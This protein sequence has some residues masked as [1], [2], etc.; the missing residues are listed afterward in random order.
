VIRKEPLGPEARARLRHEVAMLERLRGVAG[1]PQLLDMPVLPDSIVLADVG[2]TSLDDH[3]Q[4]VDVGDLVEFGVALAMVV[5]AMHRRG[6]MHR[7]IS[8]GN[9]LI[10]DSNA[11][12]LVDFALAT[13]FAE[14]R[15]EFTHH[16]EIRGTLAYL[17][18]EQTGRTGRPVD[19][20]ADLYALGA[21]LYELATGHAPFGAGDPLRLVHDHLARVPVPPV[22]LNPA[23]EA[24][25][26]DI[27]MH[28]LEK[29]PDSRYQTAEGVLYDLQRLQHL[30]DES[31][32]AVPPRV[33]EHD[34]PV[35]L[36]PPSSLVGRDDEV[37]MLASALN[38]ALT[39]RCRAVLVSGAPGVGKT[40]MIDQLR[41]VVTGS[42][43]WF[44]AGKFDPYRR[45]LE[46]DAIYRAL[47]ALGRLLLA[48]PEEELARLRE[49][50][51]QA[52]GANAG[53]LTAMLPEFAALLGVAPDPGAPL[54]AEV[55][56]QR[57]VAAA[58]R[59]VASRKRPLVM[60]IDDLQWAARTRLGFLDVLLNEEPVHGML[61]VCA[62]RDDALV[63]PHPLAGSLARWQDHPGVG[64]LRLTNLPVSG[65]V[66]M[67]AEMLHVDRATAAALA[68]LID[69]RTRGN[70]YETVELLN[71]L[72]CDGVLTAT[73]AGWRW[74]EAG[75]RAHL[76]QWEGAGLLPARVEAMPSTSRQI[77]EAMACLGG[78]TELSLLQT[79]TDTPAA[80]V[81]RALDPAL[82][83]G[84][85]VVEPGIHQAVRFRHDRIRE[86]IL[87]ALGPQRRRT[88]Q[89]AMARR[90]AEVPE[91]VAV[92]AEQYLPVVHAVDDV[93]ERRRVVEL[94][95]RAADQA[96]MIGDHALVS[97]LLTAAL[98]LVDPAEVATL[99]DL[100]S[101][102]H[103]ALYSLGRLEEADDEYRRIDAVRA[104]PLARADATVLQVHS[105]THR[106]LFAQAT[107][108]GLAALRELGIAVP[109]ADALPVE[110]DHQ[111]ERL[112]QWLSA[113]APEDD[114][115][116]PDLTD[117]SLVSAGELINAML[118]PV[119]FAAD[120]AR[121]AWLSLEAL[122][123]WIEHGPG[124]TLV[125]P[126]CHV[127]HATVELRGD[128]AA[129]YR[130][131]RRI[132][133]L[134][135]ARGYQPET[136]NARFLF[137]LL[138]WCFEPIE[139]CVRATR[140]AREGL[141]A[142]G[143]L[144]LAGY[145]Y[146][147]AAAAIDCSPSVESFAAQVEEGLSFVRRT[148]GEQ[149]VQ[150]LDSYRR[151]VRVL[152]GEGTAEE[153]E[154]GPI[155]RYADN[156]LALCYA[157]VTRALAAVIFGD[158][159]DLTRHTAAAMTL[160]TTVS[161]HYVTAVARVLRGLALC[162]Q[163]RAGG[164]DQHDALVAEFDDV[165]QWL[166]ERAADAPDNF[167]HLLRLI[168]AERAWAVGDF[169]AAAL[170]FDAARREVARH[171][172]PWQRALIAERAGRFFLA[173]GLEQTGYDALAEA[174]TDYAAWGATAKVDQLDWAYPI[175]RS[176]HG[177]DG[178]HAVA[179]P[180]DLP[181]ARST[182]ST[183]T[184]DLL[185]ILAASQALSS[186]TSVQRLHARVVEVLSEM[187]GATG[188]HL[189]LWHDD[190]R[191]WLLPAS[192]DDAVPLSGAGAQRVAPLSVLR[193]VERTRE[194]LV[195][196]DAI[197]DDRFARD[198]YFAE[199]TSC[200]LLAVPILSRGTLRAVLVLENRLIRGA[201]STERLD[202]VKL[203]A[204]QLAV[205][206]E[207]AKVYSAFR[208]VADE[209]AALR[210][211]A[212]LVA[213]GVGPELVFA[214]VAEEVGALFGADGTAIVRFE[215]D[216]QATVMGGYG[217]EHS[218]PGFRGTPDPRLA[219]ASVQA[220]G[221]AARRD[222]DDPVTGVVPES[223]SLGVRS[224]VASPIV[225]EGRVWGA[226]GVGSRNGRL[227]PDT[228]HRLDEFTALVATAIANAESRAELATSRARIV[229][230]SD[231][232][233]RRIER[234]LHDGAQ[235]RLVHTVV[236]LKLARE[237]LENADTEAV[238]LVDEALENAE[239]SI[240]EVRELARGIHPRI[241]SLG[242]LG[243]ALD[244]LARRSRL[245]V[246]VELRTERRPPERTEVTAYYVISEALTNAVKH[247][248]ATALGVTVDADAAEAVLHVTVHDD[249]A[250]GAD[251]SLGTGL[252]G[253]KDRVEALG[254]RF[255]L[256]SPRGRGTTMHIDLPLAPAAAA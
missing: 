153:A 72:R 41:P 247:A 224:A 7:D 212:T 168:E 133:A 158:P 112:Y 51:L 122:R 102:R 21:T 55:R 104:T 9:I 37:V 81:E 117:P 75:V 181:G 157:H 254:G 127:A 255:S 225:V 218:Q 58:L 205:S 125:G 97:T 159:L 11:P 231:Q 124:R 49:G 71:A 107:D 64:H 32:G 222:A 108:L 27:I 229:A 177:A 95:Q 167:L 183:G 10:S 24:P 6:V 119:Y 206:L 199:I 164:D 145:T 202:A 209:Q 111:F 230:A 96:A 129:G 194:P 131:T 47:R 198:A 151:L 226:M 246:T 190:A 5:A 245:P 220:T 150:W 94:L 39:G 126:A 56:G 93:A 99:L 162:G 166:S 130:T 79:A 138:G 186:E 48:E 89:L 25:L 185:G 236:T 228:G 45:D 253:I 123:I 17:A 33:G 52:T 210:R 134:S 197:R 140:R 42:D 105:L 200:S 68:E 250:G 120:H 156:P 91:L 100:H 15:P 19:E 90:L 74:D 165:A 23:V 84:L 73:S 238:E 82:D 14:I 219:L 30:P 170:A 54:T 155:E 98:P 213:R 69:P 43:G 8:P 233:R 4:P 31:A 2:G 136:A 192:A 38:R 249:G 251:P 62:Y 29:E 174:R 239:G 116:R 22:K 63:A 109:A 66:A 175:L 237:A 189:L 187:T 208:R 204:G 178:G 132:L 106:N 232:T 243:P 240:E 184:I 176:R 1:I 40:A 137:G 110:V 241:L 141:I 193:Y 227:L 20:R 196:N 26:S 216:G 256:D 28:L 142:G 16:T 59:V 80:E 242:G 161:G 76:G 53:L 121:V 188:V 217:F 180:P 44:V 92:A 146:H 61:V 128:Y 101:G 172:R 171:D 50:I 85:L 57:T 144:A 113:T 83:D 36:L 18:P 221:R 35:R 235:Q 65:S 244:T 78:R 87:R 215:P 115:A 34:L 207:N 195:V 60:F 211:V 12:F 3:V 88:L 114:L 86:A 169:R 135:E 147:Q 163:I 248:H 149:T 46:S 13:A 77:I 70:P 182:V 67:V 118:P 143:E 160:L 191:S 148:G 203:I 179:P 103:A 152:R 201:F 223:G 214:S 173:H 154:A 139:N 252:I 234:D